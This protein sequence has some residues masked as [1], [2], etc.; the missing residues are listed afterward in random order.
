MTNRSHESV[1]RR[2][3]L[4]ST[5]CGAAAVGLGALAPAAMGARASQ[6]AAADAVVKKPVL[7]YGMLGRTGYPVTLISFGAIRISEK[8]GTRVLRAGI[9]AGINLLHSSQVYVG[10]KSLDCIAE[11]FKADKGYRDKVFL[12]LKTFKPESEKEIDEMLKTLG[13]DHADAILTT[14]EEAD[15]KRLDALQKQQDMLIKKGKVRHTGF[16]S[17]KDTNRVM[18]LISEK[19]PK[20]FEMSLLAVPMLPVPGNSEARKHTEADRKRFAANLKTFRKNGVGI[21]SMKSGAK[22]AVTEGA[23]VFQ[24][25]AK[26][27]LEAGV[28]SILT[29]INAFDQVDMVRNLKLSSPLTPEERKAAIEFQERRSLA[30]L[31]CARCTEIC[32]NRLPVSDLMR[33]RMY[34]EEYGWPD[35]ARDEFNR[36]DLS[37]DQLASACGDCSTCTEIC[38]VGLAGAAAVRRVARLFV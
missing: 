11:L 10:G 32:P 15:P 9:D 19:A 33:I 4:R 36:L 29:S 28:D 8:L 35:H 24:P 37:P 34:Y 17:H 5:T 14:F 1:T 13:I 2:E 18:E 3:F 12:C 25:H 27:L 21:L 23:N 6:P 20:Y 26:A 7:P 31:M 30:C 38:P 22:V 16:V